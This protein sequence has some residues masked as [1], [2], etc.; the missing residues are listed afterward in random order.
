MITSLMTV[1]EG[2]ACMTA[3]GN[4]Q[5]LCS[6]LFLGRMQEI[7]L[8]GNEYRNFNK[9]TSA[10]AKQMSLGSLPIN[11]ATFSIDSNHENSSELSMVHVLS[12]S[13]TS[14]LNIVVVHGVMYWSFY[15]VPAACMKS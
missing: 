1:N 11:L 3:S 9:L 8:M 13:Y 6:H 15:A 10:F 7:F 12:H 4:S 2:Q 5:E 14:L